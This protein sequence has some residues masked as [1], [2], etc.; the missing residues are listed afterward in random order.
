M[1]A[2]RVQPEAINYI[3]D[4]MGLDIYDVINGSRTQLSGFLS[5]CRKDVCPTVNCRTIRRWVHHYIKFGE[6][7]EDSKQW[8]QSHEK[9]LV[10]AVGA[11]KQW[12]QSHEK[13]WT[14]RPLKTTLNWQ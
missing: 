9:T 4:K 12:E 2:L 3:E 11:I 14:S 10:Q 5:M 13:P 7:P 1:N 8:E 6:L